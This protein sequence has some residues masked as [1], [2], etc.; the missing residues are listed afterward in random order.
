MLAESSKTKSELLFEH[1]LT[2][3]GITGFRFEREF[4]ETSKKP[5]YS[6]TFVDEEI[7]FEVKEF[8]P[9]S[10]DFWLGARGY[11]AYGPIREKIDQ[12]RDKFQKL[13]DYCCCLVLYNAGKPLVDLGWKY[14]YGAMLGDL[15]I[16]F[17]FAPHKGLIVE[18]AEVA[19][20]YGGKMHASYDKGGFPKKAQNTTVSAILVLEKFRI[21]E[22]RFEWARRNKER[23]FGRRLTDQEYSELI[24]PFKT[25]GGDA[26]LSEL[27]VVANEN[28]YARKPLRRDIFRG[29]HDERYGFTKGEISRIFAGEQIKKLE[30]EEV[31]FGKPS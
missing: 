5:D 25:K 27:R 9:T 1:Y 12:A 28:L 19:F 23:D 29:P 3:S 24:A 14:I 16:R 30:A 21:G 13:K 20:L 18:E 4:Q 11:D 17:P 8:C 31:P 10:D 15:G 2:S 22:R 26:W 6:V 7:L